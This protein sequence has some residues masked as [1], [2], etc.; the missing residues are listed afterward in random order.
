MVSGE[1]E[2]T[3]GA[4]GKQVNIPAPLVKRAT[5]VTLHSSPAPEIVEREALRDEVLFCYFQ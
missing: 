1:L 5:G 3:S 2:D 4:K